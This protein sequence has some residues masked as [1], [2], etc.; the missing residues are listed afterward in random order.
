MP[1]A[2]CPRSWSGTPR[3]CRT[4]CRADLRA[5]GLTHLTA[6][7]G[8][9]VAIVCG[10]A[11]GL[12]ALLGARR[13]VRLVLAAA[14]LAGF[15]VLARPEPSVLRAGVMGAVGLIG[16]AAARSRPAYRYWPGQ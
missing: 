7:S 10:A 3:G 5:A 11:L 8:A 14:A 6:V 4:T 12:A 1:A 13:R 16:L 2:C 9:N 15:I